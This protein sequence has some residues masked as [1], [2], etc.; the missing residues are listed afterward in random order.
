MATT[1]NKVVVT[2]NQPQASAT[3]NETLNKWSASPG[4]MSDINNVIY[5]TLLGT[6]PQMRT[7]TVV[8]PMKESVANPLAKFLASESGQGVPR[9][10]GNIT[11]EFSEGALDSAQDFMDIDP[12]SFFEENIK[13]PAVNMFKEQFD[14]AREDFAGRLSGSDRFRTEED[15]I[16]RFTR[17]LAS[18]QAE[19]EMGL[20]QQQFAMAM[21]IKEQNN[22]EAKAQY[23]DWMKSLPQYNPALEMS[24]KFLNEQTSSGTTVLSGMDEGSD[25]IIGAILKMFSG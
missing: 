6:S 20:P 23:N 1:T 25:G 22:L 18:T 4:F 19:F 2:N 21:Q 7:S 5:D 12:H 11:G 24:L 15:R 17:D 14:I 16:S 10:D 13:A 8:D 9:F 3:R